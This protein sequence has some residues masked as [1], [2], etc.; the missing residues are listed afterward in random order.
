MKANLRD[1]EVC[2]RCNGTGT[3]VIRGSGYSYSAPCSEPIHASLPLDTDLA[4]VCCGCCLGLTV[5]ANL[6]DCLICDE[7]SNACPDC[8]TAHRET[9]TE[10]EVR[11]AR[12]RVAA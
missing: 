9:H 8:I 5:K 12:A 6:S 3:Q 7:V 1:K 10:E 2:S 11:E 4:E